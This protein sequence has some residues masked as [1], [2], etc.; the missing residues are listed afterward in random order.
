MRV[1][2]VPR[3][4]SSL[5]LGPPEPRDADDDRRLR[6]LPTV[7]ARPIPADADVESFIGEARS[8]ATSLASA[9]MARELASGADALERAE[10]RMNEAVFAFARACLALEPRVR[11]MAARRATILA[12]AMRPGTDDH[13]LWNAHSWLASLEPEVAA[14][15]VLV[16]RGERRVADA[17]DLRRRAYHSLAVW[18]RRARRC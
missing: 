5:P 7:Y 3:M 12:H 11:A 9:A 2:N 10:A 14:K 13:E 1:A 6:D 16:V 15:V 18:M 4:Q 8:L 17:E